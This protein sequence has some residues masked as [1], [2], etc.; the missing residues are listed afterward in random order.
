[1]IDLGDVVPLEF[2]V[3]DASESRVNA[4]TVA[5]TITLP[6][7]TVSTPTVTNPPAQVGLY[8]YDHIT[9]QAGRHTYRWVATGPAVATVDVFD[10]ADLSIGPIVSLAATK[11]HL[12]MDPEPGPD[13]EEL[14][15]VI[16]SA[17]PIVEDVAGPVVTRAFTEVHDGGPFLVLDRSPAVSLT[18]VAAV[19]TGGPSY[20][21]VDLDLDQPTG[22]VRRLGGGRFRGPLRVTYVAGRRVVPGNIQQ[23]CLE[24]IRHAWETQ[25]G[26]S[27]VRPGFGEEQDLAPTPSGFLVPRRAMEWLRPHA[28]APMMA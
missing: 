12:N 20:L 27:S 24:I 22:V 25:R 18:S 14:R 21:A 23:G 11:K 19:L 15:G 7:G 9:T 26:H 5:L 28:R 4:A 3:V 8:T 1:M 10:V 13:D 17:T 16:Y 6:D 2:Q